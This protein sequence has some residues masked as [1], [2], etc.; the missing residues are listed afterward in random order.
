VA[1][2][3][4]RKEFVQLLPGCL[5]KIRND[6]E[7]PT[8][9]CDEFIRHIDGYA[10][11]GI[12]DHSQVFFDTNRLLGARISIAR[13][14]FGTAQVTQRLVDALITQ[15]VPGRVAQD[16]IRRAEF[17]SS[18]SRLQADFGNFFVRRFRPAEPATMWS[19][20]NPASPAD[21]VSGVSSVPAASEFVCRVGAGYTS[22]RK[23]RTVWV[24]VHR[25]RRGA[26]VARPTTFDAGTY[27]LSRFILGG[28]TRPDRLCSHLPGLDEV[29]HDA[30]RWNDAERM[31]RWP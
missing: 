26:I 2:T 30:I 27:N 16:A 13:T 25:P 31:M 5:K 7:L 29:V 17:S 28:R 1:T 11:G 19:W 20:T 21:P 3:L 14:R 23:R 4:G 10:G 6:T 24:M 8:G 9:K 18:L 15:G 12:K 22:R